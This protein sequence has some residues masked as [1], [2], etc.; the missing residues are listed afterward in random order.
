MGVG[1]SISGAE[2]NTWHDVR[3][4]SAGDEP[5]AR[6]ADERG[7]IRCGQHDYIRVDDRYFPVR[8]DRD[9]QTWRVYKEHNPAGAAVPVRYDASLG[10]WQIHDDV[11]L[12]GGSPPEPCGEPW[13]DGLPEEIM[14]T[15]ASHLP[16]ADIGRLSQVNHRLRGAFTQETQ[17]SRL[18]AQARRATQLTEFRALL[19][20]PREDREVIQGLRMSL[21]ER[22]LMALSSRIPVLPDRDWPPAIHL[23]NC[24]AM[25]LPEARQ[26][27]VSAAIGQMLE[28]QGA[29]ALARVLDAVGRLGLYASA[30][31]VRPAAPVRQIPRLPEGIE[32]RIAQ[33]SMQEARRAGMPGQSSQTAHARQAVAAVTE[34]DEPVLASAAEEPAPL[35]Q[36][37]FPWPSA[38]G[39]PA[40]ALQALKHL[41]Q[42]ATHDPAAVAA[43]LMRQWPSGHIGLWTADLANKAPDSAAA[44]L[45]VYLELL[46]ALRAGGDLTS[47]QAR[48]LLLPEIDGERHVPIS[49]VVATHWS[50]MP[51]AAEAFVSALVNATPESA[52]GQVISRLQLEQSNR[53]HP[54]IGMQYSADFYKQLKRGMKDL[55]AARRDTAA[56]RRLAEHGLIPPGRE[57]GKMARKLPAAASATAGSMRR[58]NEIV[59]NSDEDGPGLARRGRASSEAVTSITD[60][61]YRIGKHHGNWKFNLK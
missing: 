60:V 32:Q 14:Q 56:L 24:V 2:R 25:Q 23:I 47:E 59:T 34:A 35:P 50:S 41:A 20:A 37:A 30:Q 36:Q 13:L 49:T 43:E 1:F 33:L 3:A 19:S 44:P 27:R 5:H 26:K 31:R 29:L 51:L 38:Y 28:V 21:Q 52:A 8:Y 15:I 48:S 45:K 54:Q 4:S 17:A 53:H 46:D 55:P 6:E 57:L 9:A 39:S 18:L 12:A 11:G 61:N 22:P 58:M 7:V 16:D 10:T 42:A 40:S